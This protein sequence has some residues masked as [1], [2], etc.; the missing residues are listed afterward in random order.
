MSA[1]KTLKNVL[2]SGDFRSLAARKKKAYDEKTIAKTDLPKAESKGWKVQRE[3]KNSYRLRRSKNKDRLLEDRVWTLLYKMGFAHMSNSGGATLVLNPKGNRRPT[4][5][6]DVVGLDNEIALAVECKT[7]QKPKK[8]SQFQKDIAK[9]ALIR[10][11]FAEAVHKQFSLSHKRVPALA[12]FTWDLILTD[13]DIERARQAKIALFNER[14]L[15][16]YE[17]LVDHLGPA[18]K[19]QLFSD[20][21]PGREVYGLQSSLPALRAKMG[22]YTCYNFSIAPEYLLKIAYVSHRAKG[23]ATDIDTYQR[24]IKKSRLKK[25]REY[26]SDKGIFP[27]NIVINFEGKKTVRFDQKE[28]SSQGAEYGTLHLKPTYRGAWI[29][30]GQHRLFAYSGHQRA[31]TSYLNVLAFEGLEASQQAQFFIDI[32]HEQKSVKR[33]LLHELFSKLN[34]DAEDDTK[35]VGAIVSKA[36]QALNDEKD[37]PFYDRILLTDSV[38][39]NTRCISLDSIFGELQKGLYIIIPKVEYGAL[40]AGD[41]DKTLRRTLK[42]IGAWFNFIKDRATDWWNLGS[43]EGG[44]LAMNDGVAICIGVLKNVFHHLAKKKG[45]S[46]VSVTDSELVI[47][48]KPYGE[49]L[50]DYFGDLSEERKQLFRTGARG[51]QGRAAHRRQ[52]EQALHQKFADFEPP[53][54]KEDLKLQKAKTNEQAYAII[55]SIETQLK[56]IVL[57]TLKADFDGE[58]W[59]YEG[60]PQKIRTKAAERQEEEKGKGGRE[61]YLDI[62]D[63]RKIVLENWQIFQDVL[64]HGAGS[65]DK[66]TKWIEQL[67]SMRKIVMHPAKAQY[68]TWDELATLKEYKEWLFGAPTEATPS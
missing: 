35:R 54:F 64:A 60:I 57:D 36:I 7:V 14:D 25:I 43:A 24:M 61:D 3:N 65:K 26:I 50:G 37:S 1:Y 48:I 55:Q 49:A 28:G 22:N 19:Y 45:I 58:N 59:W 31:K 44:G 30:D 17:Q 6:I 40:W 56:K 34:W 67:N 27:T 5:Q 16:Y 4:N 33:G 47:Q 68:I 20:I 8:S 53:G 39:T 15:D 62:L 10:Q 23:K 38:W 46:L 42:I 63:F 21:L 51:N 13:N 9:H 11:S 18:T 29:I 52:C 66:K 41:N 32:N 12:I 2:P